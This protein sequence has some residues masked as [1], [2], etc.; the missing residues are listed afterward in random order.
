MAYVVNTR[1]LEACHPLLPLRTLLLLG[2]RGLSSSTTITGNLPSIL[3]TL[4]A[5][6][7]VFSAFLVSNFCLKRTPDLS[8]NNR[9]TDKTRALGGTMLR[10]GASK[11]VVYICEPPTEIKHKANVQST[12]VH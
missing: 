4:C 12:I 3:S 8:S 10:K 11:H 2:T 7:S 5:P 6:V 1:N 9:P